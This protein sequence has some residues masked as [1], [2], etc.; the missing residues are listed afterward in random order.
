MRFLKYIFFFILIVIIGLSLYI[1]TLDG[2]YD[3]QSKRI[4]KAPAEMVFN[5]VNDYK[6]WQD[7]GPWYE[8]DSTI[9]AKYPDTTS[10][11]GA[12]YAWTGKEGAGAMKTIT[13]TPNKEIVQQIDFN[14]GS[15]PEVYWNFNEVEEG[16]EVTWGMRGENTFMEKA[17]W[18]FTGDIEENMKPMYDRG[19]ELLDMHLQEEMDKYNIEHKGVVDHGGGYYVYQTTS[20]SMNE[21]SNKMSELFT[22]VGNFVEENNIDVYGNPFSITHKWDEQNKTSM[23]STCLPVKD[24]VIT[25]GDVLSGYLKPQKTFKTVLQGDYKYLEKAWNGAFEALSNKGYTFKENSEPFEVYVVNSQNTPNKS[26]WITEI[27]IPIE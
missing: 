23:F 17:Y 9:V 14:T 16:T 6:N 7:W 3:V 2:S 25:T 19:L 11:V 22:N 5:D 13:L 1:A 20:A 10:G 8:M 15:T 26:K 27:Y 12:S 24:R 4:I 21:L 18:L